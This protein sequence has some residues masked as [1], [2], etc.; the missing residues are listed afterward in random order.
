MRKDACPGKYLRKELD[1]DLIYLPRA[2][3]LISYIC[4]LISLSKDDL[5]TYSAEHITIIQLRLAW[6]QEDLL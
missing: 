4:Q 2:K 6:P 5:I 3:I 1:S